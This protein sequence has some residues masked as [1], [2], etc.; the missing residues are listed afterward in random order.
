MRS[1]VIFNPVAGSAKDYD[2]VQKQLKQLSPDLVH[3]TRKSGD[4]AAFARAA[5]RD[6]YRYVIAAGGGGPL[7]QGMHGVARNASSGRVGFFPLGSREQFVRSVK[8]PSGGWG[9]N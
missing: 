7:K 5:V 6:K 9:K 1:C 4:A 8:S 2:A 3:V